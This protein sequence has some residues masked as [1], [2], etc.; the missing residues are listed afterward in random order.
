M[1]LYT[2]SLS[3]RTLPGYGPDPLPAY[4]TPSAEEH[5]PYL[6]EAKQTAK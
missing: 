1:V 6:G 4:F 5:P 2:V 3:K